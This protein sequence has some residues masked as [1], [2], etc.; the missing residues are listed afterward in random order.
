[1]VSHALTSSFV[2]QN[3]LELTQPYTRYCTIDA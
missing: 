3:G 2:C 1:M